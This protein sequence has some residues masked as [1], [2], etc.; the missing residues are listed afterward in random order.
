MENWGRERESGLLRPALSY[1]G[2]RAV[3]DE[4]R[5]QKTGRIGPKRP[6]GI[7]GRDD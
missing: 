6:T 4:T 7:M 2:A 5:D 1:L 3:G